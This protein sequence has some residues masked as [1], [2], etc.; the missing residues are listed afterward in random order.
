MRRRLD[1]DNAQLNTVLSELLAQDADITIR[2]VAR[3]HPT[4]KNA[5][6]FV[7]DEERAG[8]I[9]RGIDKQREARAV[10]LEPHKLKAASLTEQLAARDQEIV[11]LKDQIKALVTSHA[12]CV[13]AV[14]VHGGMPALERFWKDYQAV[15]TMVRESKAMPES[16]DVINLPVPA[17]KGHK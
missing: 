5:S 1:A 4:I 9:Q 3:R 8:L 10:V 7:R 15:G 12:A 2:E 16:A 17:K 11:Q 14:M 6:A 13:R